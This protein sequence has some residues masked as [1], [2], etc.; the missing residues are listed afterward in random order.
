MRG[1]FPKGTYT[2]HILPQKRRNWGHLEPGRKY[3]VSREFLDFDND[4]HTVG[5]S[6][7]FL[8]YSFHH[9]DEGLS[10]FVTMDGEQEWYLPL[11]G[12]A[13]QQGGVMD[14]LEL[15]IKLEAADQSKK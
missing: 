6:W 15:Y 5:K 10:L 1:P 11:Q 3:V 7:I 4:V 8:G 14:Q 13:D 9:M 12:G 2:G